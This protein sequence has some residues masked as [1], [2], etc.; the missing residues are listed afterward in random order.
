MF[1]TKRVVLENKPLVDQIR[2]KWDHRSE[3]HSFASLFLWQRDMGLMIRID[4][5]AYIVRCLSRDDYCWYFPCGEPEQCE[6]WIRELLKDPRS[7]RLSYMRE[8]DVRFL[9]ERFP[10]VFDIEFAEGD[11]EY[12]YDRA[13]YIAMEGER[14]R[15]I[16][17]GV[18]QLCS[19]YSVRAEPWVAENSADMEKVLKLWHTNIPGEDG[20][21][22]YET[23]RLLISHLD[24]LDVTGVIVY[25]DDQP[26]AMSAGFPLSDNSF[27]IAFSK[28]A[29]HLNGLP[30]FTRQALARMLPEKFTILNG[31]DDLGIPGIRMVKKLMRPIGQIRMYE[32]QKK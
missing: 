14:Y 16:R 15:R 1:E 28:C 13:E 9:E 5:G 6:Y 8:E 12:L 23:S 17:K 30:D 22:D 7:L 25:I 10:G 24:D 11:S 18:R 19:E 29:V 26:V 4:N 31:E 21:E 2:A 27:D 3:S 20:L 32:A